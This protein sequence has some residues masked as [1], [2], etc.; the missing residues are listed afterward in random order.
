MHTYTHT[1]LFVQADVAKKLIAPSGKG[2]AEILGSD[3][4]VVADGVVVMA[5][6]LVLDGKYGGAIDLLKRAL[7]MYAPLFGRDHPRLAYVHEL[8][9]GE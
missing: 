3:H 1:Y 6:V 7:T 9:A 2:L 8:L 4:C 5:R